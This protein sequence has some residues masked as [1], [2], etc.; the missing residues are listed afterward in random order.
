M[1]SI[2]VNGSINYILSA[3]SNDRNALQRTF[4]LSL[5]LGRDRL[6]SRGG[7]HLPFHWLYPSGEDGCQ[8]IGL[9]H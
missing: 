7:R 6:D 2:E 9:L 8:D 3:L 5:F 4:E 1:L